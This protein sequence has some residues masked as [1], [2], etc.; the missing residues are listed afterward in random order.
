MMPVETTP[1]SYPVQTTPES[2]EVGTLGNVNERAPAFEGPPPVARLPF[3]STSE[4]RHFHKYQTRFMKL[5]F[6]PSVRPPYDNPWSHGKWRRKVQRMCWNAKAWRSSLSNPSF[7]S[8]HDNGGRLSPTEWS[9][10][11]KA[12][13]LAEAGRTHS[14]AH[15]LAGAGRT[16]SM[17]LRASTDTQR[18]QR[19]IS[20]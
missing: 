18:P 15:R 12:H 6:P 20:R 1:E 14:K 2:E 8:F 5:K 7:I 17:A 19:R 3:N 9:R 16:H 11:R 10:A 13:R 4:T